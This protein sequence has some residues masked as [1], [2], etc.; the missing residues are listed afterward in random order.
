MEKLG[1]LLSV[2]ITAILVGITVGLTSENVM[3]QEKNFQSGGNPTAPPPQ[4]LLEIEGIGNQVIT[5]PVNPVAGGCINGDVALLSVWIENGGIDNEITGKVICDST[6][7][8]IQDKSVSVED[9]GNNIRN[10]T[11]VSLPQING[12]ADCE[13][14]YVHLNNPNS[15]WKVTC[16]FR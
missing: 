13:A 14:S 11:V 1:I 15:K 16:E 4:L 12:I 9:S 8:N 3:D 2:V 6:T 5:P 7:G 10:S